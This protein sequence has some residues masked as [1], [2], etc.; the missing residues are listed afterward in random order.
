M[1]RKRPVNRTLME[2][3]F[4]HLIN[5]MSRKDAVNRTLMELK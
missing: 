1:L 2:L 3:K 5:K 4:A